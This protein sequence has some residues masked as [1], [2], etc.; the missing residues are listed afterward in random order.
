[1]GSKLFP[2]KQEQT[3]E[4]STATEKKIE[5]ESQMKDNHNIQRRHNSERIDSNF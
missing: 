5:R 4:F 2:L 3:P 1:V